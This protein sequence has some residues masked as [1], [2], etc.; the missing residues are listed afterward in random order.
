LWV[1]E[2]FCFAPKALELQLGFR[3]PRGVDQPG[4]VSQVSDR[5]PEVGEA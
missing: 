2:R 5:Y 3:A 4:E 1:D